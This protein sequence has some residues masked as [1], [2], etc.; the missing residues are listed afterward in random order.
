MGD[1]LY[2]GQPNNMMNNNMN[3]NMNNT[4]YGLAQPL[5]NNNNQPYI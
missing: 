2:I 5:N 3:N 4:A 1:Q